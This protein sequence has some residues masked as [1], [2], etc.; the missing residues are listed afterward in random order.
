VRRDWLADKTVLA[1]LP[2]AQFPR[3]QRKNAD[4]LGALPFAEV[5]KTEVKGSERCWCDANGVWITPPLTR[6]RWLRR[7]KEVAPHLPQA[8][9]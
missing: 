8:G 6:H 7:P 2:R 5:I 9:E 4:G 3:G 1:G